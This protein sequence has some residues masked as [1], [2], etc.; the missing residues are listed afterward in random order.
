MHTKGHSICRLAIAVL[1]VFFSC[2]LLF[3]FFAH[4]SDSNFIGYTIVHDPIKRLLEHALITST[5]DISSKI[6]NEDSV[7]IA[8]IMG[9]DQESLEKRA[10][11]TAKLYHS[12]TVTY[13]LTLS[14]EGKTEYNSELG[15]NLT[16]NEWM[17]RLLAAHRIKTTDI[18]L[19]AFE[20]SYFG[21]LSEIRGL[22]ELCKKM[23][24]HD[25]IIISSDYHTARIEA[26][27]KSLN[28]NSV[29]SYRIC[30][31]PDRISLFG[32][33][34]EYIKLIAY[35]DLILPIFFKQ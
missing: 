31:C 7:Q 25:I 24:W 15:R 2:L 32:L 3:F 27:S 20:P 4:E 17:M 19:V 23:N 22:K 29:T 35:R 28:L 30:G 9:G 34:R 14:S 5:C 10:S 6:S 21:T 33:L 8:Y 26:T 1:I 11:L 12:G 16:N 13:V 18:E